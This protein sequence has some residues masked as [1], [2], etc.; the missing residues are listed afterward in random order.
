MEDRM[1]TKAMTLIGLV[2]ALL[3]IAGPIAVTIPL[4]PVP[5]SLATLAICFAV[6]VLGMKNGTI[7]CLLYLLMG[8]I[9][10]PIFSGFSGGIGKLLGPTGG[11]LIG[12]IALAAISGFFIEK[13]QTNRFMHGIG[14]V[15][16]TVICYMLGSIWLMQQAKVTFYTSI[17]MGV[18]PFLPGDVL[19]L[20]VAVTLG[21]VLRKHL[22]KAGLVLFP[23]N[24]NK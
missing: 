16:G 7:S 8:M 18:L 1:K 14:M 19:K 21:P 4:S 3:C 11:Y 15:L 22:L 24:M 5:I 23:K 13:W 2:T 6:Y 12:Y 9:G 20:I 10:L 17:T